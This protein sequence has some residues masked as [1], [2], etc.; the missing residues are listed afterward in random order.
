MHYMYCSMCVASLQL[1]RSD[2]M[3]VVGV[4]SVG[5]TLC[6]TGWVSL[7]PASYCNASIL[8]LFPKKL[9]PL[10][11]LPEMFHAC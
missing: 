7:I 10:R 5:P 9:A 4:W 1:F 6:R 2:G 3:H 11:E 8:C